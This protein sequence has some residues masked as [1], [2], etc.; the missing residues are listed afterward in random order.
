MNK[1]L[2]GLLATD[3]DCLNY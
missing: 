1:L 2:S 3:L